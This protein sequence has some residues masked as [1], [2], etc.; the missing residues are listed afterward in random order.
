L[1]NLRTRSIKPTR[2]RT[3]MRVRVVTSILLL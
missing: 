3:I 2:K 1:K